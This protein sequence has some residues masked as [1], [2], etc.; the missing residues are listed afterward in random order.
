MEKIPN[1]LGDIYD[2]RIWEDFL[3]QKYSWCLALNVDWFQPFS[4][5]TDSVGA[6]Y[7]VI[8]NLPRELRYKR[9]NMILVGII[10]GPREPKKI[11]IHSCLL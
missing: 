3:A 5:V 1:V 4:H 11:L 2:G 7:M 8:L 9:E 10:P 6:L